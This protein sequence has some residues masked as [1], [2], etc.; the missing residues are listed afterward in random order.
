MYIPP[1][2]TLLIKIAFYFLYYPY[3][4]YLLIIR[5]GHYKLKGMH[6]PNLQRIG[7]LLALLALLTLLALSSV[8]LALS[9]SVFKSRS[10][11]LSSITI[12]FTA[13]R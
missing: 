12:R 10:A 3:F 1:F 2:I 4:Y 6:I 9:P 5:Q 13:S 8:L 11:V 7:W